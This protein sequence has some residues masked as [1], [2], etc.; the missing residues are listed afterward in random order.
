M[1]CP[2]SHAYFR[3]EPFPFAELRAAGVNVCLGT[4]SLASIGKTGRRLPELDVFAELR[5]FATQ[6]PELVPTSALDL[7]TRNSA[8][9]LGLRGQIGQISRGAHADLLVLRPAE[10]HPSAT[11]ALLH[12]PP[13]ILAVMIGGS[14]IGQPPK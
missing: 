5:A 10:A 9:A 6:H 7:V 2:R 12:V 4:D 1:H 14:W 11:E 3:H 13:D 8:T